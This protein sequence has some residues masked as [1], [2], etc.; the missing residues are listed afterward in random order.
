MGASPDGAVAFDSDDH[1]G[2][3]PLF[4]ATLLR[5]VAALFPGV[6]LLTL[7]RG[8]ALPFATPSTSKGG[9]IGCPRA[10]RHAGLPYLLPPLCVAWAAESNCLHLLYPAASSDLATTLRFRPTAL[11]ADRHSPPPF[12]FSNAHTPYLPLLDELHL[13]Q[14]ILQ[15]HMH[16]KAY[17]IVQFF[18]LYPTASI[19]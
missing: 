2:S 13:Q 14:S 9:A 8:D 18:K 1:S 3:S 16:A 15:E 6:P 12:L 17:I 19:C 11:G 10:Q 7:A 5:R 4:A